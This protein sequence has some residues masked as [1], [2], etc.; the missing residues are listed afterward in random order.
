MRLQ[1]LVSQPPDRAE[2]AIAAV[3]ILNGHIEPS[4]T[5]RIIHRVRFHADGTQLANDIRQARR[6]RF[7]F[8]QRSRRVGFVGA[9]GSLRT[10][11]QRCVRFDLLRRGV[12]RLKPSDA[13]FEPRDG[14]GGFG[15]TDFGLRVLRIGHR[16]DV[17]QHGGR[18]GDAR[19]GLF[20]VGA[21]L[22]EFARDVGSTGPALAAETSNT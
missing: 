13:R 15:V 2:L 8:G 22:I 12:R 11:K 3:V 21:A 17:R 1:G 16:G 5:T 9:L 19:A 7:V 10:G 20:D 18:C 6:R 4:P 14:A